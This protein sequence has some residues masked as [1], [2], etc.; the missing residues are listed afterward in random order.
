MFPVSHEFFGA[1]TPDHVQALSYSE[2]SVGI[3]RGSA[4]NT[5]LFKRLISPL[6]R[7]EDKYY[8]VIRVSTRRYLL[9]PHFPT[10]FA[11][12]HSCR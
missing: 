6:A 11:F 1:P 2:Q 3:M 7:E 9:E 10:V 8:S 12:V 5:L 4:P